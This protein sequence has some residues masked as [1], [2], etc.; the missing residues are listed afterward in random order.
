MIA[1]CSAGDGDGAA[2]AT[3]PSST[4]T[5]PPSTPSPTTTTPTS[6]TTTPS[7]GTIRWVWPPLW[8]TPGQ[9]ASTE[10]LVTGSDTATAVTIASPAFSTAA[11][12]EL[13]PATGRW[14]ATLLPDVTVASRTAELTARATRAT[15]ELTASVT[16]PVVAAS[17]V[18]APTM[19][20][21][22][23]I[24]IANLSYGDG[25]NEIGFYSPPGDG[26]TI[27]P[28]SIDV[29][30]RDGSVLVLDNA[31]DRVVIL[32]PDGTTRRIV[33]LP[34]EGALNDINVNG[35][36]GRA[37]VSQFVIK[38]HGEYTSVYQIDLE[39]GKY[40]TIGPE[41]PP[42]PPPGHMDMIWN[43]G[44][45]T[46]YG[47]VI[48]LTSGGFY[49]YFNTDTEAL[50]M[51]VDA[52]RWFEP[53]VDPTSGIGVRYGSTALTVD[54]PERIEGH[55]DRW[56]TADGT[57]WI[58]VSSTDGPEWPNGPDNVDF[59][60]IRLDPSCPA[61]TATPIN[62]VGFGQFYTRSFTVLG[63]TAY[64]P[65][66]GRDRYTIETYTLPAPPCA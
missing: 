17:T 57:I 31:N 33:D 25:P 20:D 62:F 51:S 50:V 55:I 21:V 27:T 14:R 37:T 58:T 10:L 24:T 41:Q 29:D 16:V 42:L 60:L 45:H 61:A 34:E 26:M 2:T 66:V 5:G 46:I 13:D 54:I 6:T 30:A 65:Q 8:L 49:P 23:P 38:N 52:Y 32:N 44:D 40:R 12:A 39:T 9:A 11:S 35:T 15:G 19:L 53:V 1:A 3:P 48:L 36:T 7:A 22:T 28:A 64:V 47:E 18:L 43:P 4:G 59:F 56:I 63:D